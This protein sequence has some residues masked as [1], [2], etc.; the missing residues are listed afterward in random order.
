MA[1]I[2]KRGSKWQIQVRR[3]NQPAVSQ[4]FTHKIDADG[5]AREMERAIDRGEL[6]KLINDTVCELTVGDLP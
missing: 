3:K 4:S 1:I 6:G 5:W 2:R